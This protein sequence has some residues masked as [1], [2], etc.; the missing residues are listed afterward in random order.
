MPCDS[1]ITSKVVLELRADNLRFLKAGLEDCGYIV[2]VNNGRVTFHS[3]D[4]RLNGSFVDG[5]LKLEGRQELV[6]DFD[7]NA[8]KR[9]Y[10]RQVVKQTAQR[11]GWKVTETGKTKGFVERGY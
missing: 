8:V 5:K 4:Y 2:E 11:F 9:A 3:M 6:R 1:V 10:S 7:I